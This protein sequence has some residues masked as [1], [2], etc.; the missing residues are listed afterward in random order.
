MSV[1]AVTIH[2]YNRYNKMSYIGELCQ[3]KES[4]NSMGCVSLGGIHNRQACS[5][6]I[7]Q[8]RL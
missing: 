6:F 1:N 5:E 4:A 2:M 7:T 3:R 8:S